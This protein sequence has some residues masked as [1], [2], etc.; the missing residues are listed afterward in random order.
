MFAI[1]RFQLEYIDEQIAV[2]EEHIIPD[3]GN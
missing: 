2:S 1:Y 3:G